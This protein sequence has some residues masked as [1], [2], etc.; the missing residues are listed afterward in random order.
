MHEHVQQ[1]VRDLVRDLER[2]GYDRESALKLL[3]D[4][5]DRQA[6]HPPKGCRPGWPS[7]SNGA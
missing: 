4:M 5:V 1:S 7:R 3:M 2:R 6:T